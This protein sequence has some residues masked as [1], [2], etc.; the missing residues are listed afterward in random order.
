MNELIKIS[1]NIQ[2]NSQAVDA[3][4]LW[5]TLESKKDF[6]EWIKNKVINSN[7]FIEGEDYCLLPQIG[8]Q[9]NRGGHNKIDYALTLNTAKQVALME[10]TAKGKE[11]RQYFINCEQKL[12]AYMQLPN[13]NNPIEAARAWA[14]EVEKKQGLQAIVELQQS[15]L[16]EAAPKVEYHDKVLANKGVYTVTQIAKTFGLS[17]NRLNQILEDLKIQYKNRETWVLYQKYQGMGYTT[18]NTHLYTNEYGQDKKSM[19]TVWT[20]QGRRFI[21]IQLTEYFKT[22]PLKQQ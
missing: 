22:H 18:T 12:K 20:E 8:E 9:K 16:K 7:L 4:E 5:Y 10:N 15:E 14:D 17:A 2:L 3:R 6:S 1:E 13:F 21:Y 11:I 19:L